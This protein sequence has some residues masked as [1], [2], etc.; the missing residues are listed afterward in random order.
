MFRGDWLRTQ[1]LR[2]E[3]RETLVCCSFDVARLVHGYQP[4][5]RRAAPDWGVGMRHSL[6]SA[7]TVACL[8]WAWPAGALADSLSVELRVQLF[9]PSYRWSSLETAFDVPSSATKS[10]YFVP[11]LGA[12]FYSKSGHGALVDVDY[13]F[14][15]DTDEFLNIFG[16]RYTTDFTVA[17]AGYA[18]RYVLASRRDPERLAWALTPHASLAAGAAF[19]ELRGSSVV[20]R[21]RSPVVGGRV[22]FDVDLHINRFFL[23]WSLRYEGLAHTKGAIRASHFFSWNLIPVFQMGAVI[24][25]KV[26]KPR[27]ENGVLPQLDGY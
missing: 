16:A 14:D 19:S 26:Q 7:F 24:G 6:T 25:R 17:H 3:Q 20:V 4:T 23:G 15:M 12:R 21:D 27:E 22:G 10:F 5:S 11:A 1:N 2:A 8:V 18:Y 9:A 13:R